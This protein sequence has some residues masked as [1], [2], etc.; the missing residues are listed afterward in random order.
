MSSNG[1]QPGG[2]RT[3]P[4]GSIQQESSSGSVQ[5]SELG[6]SMPAGY[7]VKTSPGRRTPDSEQR[8]VMLAKH[9]NASDTD[10]QSSLQKK[11]ARRQPPRVGF[12]PP[13]PASQ[14][15]APKAPHSSTRPIPVSHL[16]PGQQQ[17]QQQQQDPQLGAQKEHVSLQESAEAHQGG[18]TEPYE[19]VPPPADTKK[20]KK[21][22]LFGA[23]SGVFSPSVQDSHS[24]G[25][26]SRDNSYAAKS[27]ASEKTRKVSNVDEQARAKRL[28]KEAGEESV[29]DKC[30]ACYTRVFKTKK[31]L[32]TVAVIFALILAALL[33]VG[34][35][36]GG[37][38]FGG[39]DDSLDNAKGAETLIPRP[40]KDS[41]TVS[42]TGTAPTTAPAT[43]GNGNSP[44][45]TPTTEGDG[46]SPTTTPSPPS[47]QPPTKASIGGV[48]TRSPTPPPTLGPTLNPTPPPTPQ[49]TKQPTMSPTKRPTLAP[50]RMP[51]T[52]TPTKGPTPAPTER[53]SPSPSTSEPSVSPTSFPTSSPTY[54]L[55]DLTP[56]GSTLT[57][58]QSGE[59][60]GY[61]V[62]LSGNGR[63][64]AVG[65]PFA[66]ASSKTEA[67]K[68]QVYEWRNGS[69]NDRGTSLLGRNAQ[70][71][72]GSAIG[73]SEDGSILV[74]SEPTYRGAA[75]D[76]SGNVRTFLYDS[77]AGRYNAIGSE[78]EG[79]ALSDH[80]GVSL[81]LS[82]DGKRLAV[83]APYHDNSSG[84]NR[85]VSGQVRTFEWKRNDWEALGSPLT[86]VSHFDW[87]GWTVDLNDDGDTMCIGAPRNLDYG[88]YVACYRYENS[89]WNILGGR[90]R[91]SI[92]PTRYD[93]NFGHSLRINGNRVAIGSPGKNWQ[94]SQVSDSGMV[95]VFE[96][97]ESTRNWQRLGNSITPSEPGQGD[98]L[99]FAVDLQDSTLIVSTPGKDN[100]GQVD[101]YH[102]DSSTKRWEVS[103]NPLIGSAGSNFGFSVHL[104]TY[105]AVGS[106]V[107]D[108]TNA[109]TVNV[110]QQL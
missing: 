73:L 74:V 68:V 60:F 17:Q 90:I 53:P 75:G 36:L 40:G 78:L 16:M 103:P 65:I 41:P 108:G 107:S 57:G 31:G 82:K 48:P 27:Y 100:R 5:S 62:A 70:D 38:F 99:G 56:L 89:G 26:E 7:Q 93:D 66:S 52:S 97:N 59:K 63:I 49:P 79:V 30:G 22:K 23:L 83:G 87:F 9:P 13:A 37:N 104:S 47:T 88:G 51:T 20:P 98:Q 77:G 92:N 15:A 28:R 64:M 67:G 110:Y 69:W 54:T 95:V 21:K 45:T 35:A 11:Q 94:A 25:E 10:V 86:G 96:Y 105:L 32:I 71:K 29:G 102:Y 3:P 18:F 55:R 8:L 46:D 58:S 2:P 85:L 6:L 14:T 4:R 84:D 42:P 61:S 44:T 19:E 12:Q 39:G 1:R 50:T 33:A 24:L 76:R 109:G 91:N 34:A 81:A 80:F 101:L 106:A 43:G 72:F